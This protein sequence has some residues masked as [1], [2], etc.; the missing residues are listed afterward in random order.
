MGVKS[1]LHV[2]TREK[3]TDQCGPGMRTPAFSQTLVNDAFE[4]ARPGRPRMSGSGASGF[5]ALHQNV[6]S[7]KY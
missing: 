6:L 5:Q 1:L 2:T 3:L 4:S 7:L